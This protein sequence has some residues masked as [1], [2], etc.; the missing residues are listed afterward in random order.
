M[1]EHACKND[2]Q[3]TE[4]AQSQPGRG[5]QSRPQPLLEAVQ[6]ASHGVLHV[7]R[8]VGSSLLESKDFDPHTRR[9]LRHA[10]S[11]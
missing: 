8:G 3:K 9:E 2:N 10:H 7:G 4:N 11:H 5:L 1:I 6:L